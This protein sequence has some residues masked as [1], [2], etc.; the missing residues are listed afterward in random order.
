NLRTPWKFRFKTNAWIPLDF[1][2]LHNRR[3]G[4]EEIEKAHDLRAACSNYAEKYVLLDISCEMKARLEKNILSLGV[5][6]T[7][8]DETCSCKGEFT[9]DTVQSESAPLHQNSTENCFNLRNLAMFGIEPEYTHE[10]AQQRL[11]LKILAKKDGADACEVRLALMMRPNE[12]ICECNLPVKEHEMETKNP[13]L[14]KRFA[15]YEGRFVRVPSPTFGELTHPANNYLAQYVRTA[16]EMDFSK[17]TYFFESV[18]S[19]QRPQLVLTFYGDE[20][21]SSTVRESLRKLVW[22][23]SDSTLTWILTDGLQHGIS[24]TVSEAT[25]HYIEAYGLG[26]VESIGIVPWRRMCC[27]SNMSPGTY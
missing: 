23:A 12:D 22:K 1:W 10:P 8:D 11:G 20:V 26:L 17:L 27:I 19:L 15:T 5:W 21:S 18:W 16:D 2:H 4:R 7:Y 14:K 25:K 9:L 13:V 6:N 24:P 3:A